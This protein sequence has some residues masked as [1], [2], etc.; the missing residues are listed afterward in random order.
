MKIMFTVGPLRSVGYSENLK[1]SFM[2]KTIF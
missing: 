2:S 1:V